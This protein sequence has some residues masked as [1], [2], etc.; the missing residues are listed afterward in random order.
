MVKEKLLGYLIPKMERWCEIAIHKC[1]L[2][3]TLFLE[4]PKYLACE[5]P[6]VV[7]RKITNRHDAYL[8]ANCD[9]LFSIL[10]LF[11]SQIAGIKLE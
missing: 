11:H 2:A 4:Y 7:F 3:I 1:H 9:Y 8:E 5:Y 6:N 10:L